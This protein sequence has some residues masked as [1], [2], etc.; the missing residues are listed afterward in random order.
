MSRDRDPFER[1]LEVIRLRLRQGEGLQG[2]ALAINLLAKDLAVSQTPVREALAWLA[3]EG[4]IVRTRAGYVGRSHDPS[5]LAELYRLNLAHVLAALSG[6]ARGS[7]GAP[8]G[9]IR[10]SPWPL[11]EG[12][13]PN[14]V[15]DVIVAL[16][17]DRTL[18]ASL[19]RTREPLSPF[20]PAEALVIGD[21][22]AV[23]AELAGAYP[24]PTRLKAIARGFYRRRMQRAAVLLETTLERLRI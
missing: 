3:G 15:F 6:E 11:T 22:D 2:Q 4:L 13:D 5:S 18:L 1:A 7:A 8:E 24:D 17:G 14:A 9:R 21:A 20:M 12:G 16:A 23:M 19:R 10:R